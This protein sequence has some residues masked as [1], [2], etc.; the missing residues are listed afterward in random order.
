MINLV[1]RPSGR[2]ADHASQ[3][4]CQIQ[5]SAVDDKP[6]TEAFICVLGN[7]FS[8]GSEPPYRRIERADR[9]DEDVSQFEIPNERGAALARN[10]PMRQA[11]LD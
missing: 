6:R 8:A 4:L 2:H 10:G 7:A 5:F 9:T 11:Q 1:S 3:N